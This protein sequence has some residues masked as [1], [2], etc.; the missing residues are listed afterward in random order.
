MFSTP[1]ARIVCPFAAD[2]NALLAELVVERAGGSGKTFSYKAETSGELT[3]WGDPSV[4]R[5]TRWVARA[6]HQVVEALTGKTLAAAYTESLHREAGAAAVGGEQ[7]TRVGVAVS[8]SWASL[9][10]PGDDHEAHFH[11]NT[12]LAA[13]YYVSAPKTCELDLLDPRPYVDYFDSGISFAGDRHRVRI[14]C[15]PGELVIFPGW[16]R[17]GVPPYTGDGERISLSWNLNYAVHG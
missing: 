13:I 14:S 3:S 17:H 8:R 16:L 11:P 12:A 2:I 9:Y 6:A 15:L 1:V 10:R 7:E 5:L 4:D